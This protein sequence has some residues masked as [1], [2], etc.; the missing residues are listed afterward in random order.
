MDLVDKYLLQG[1]DRAAHDFNKDAVVAGGV[2]GLGDLFQA[3]KLRQRRRVVLGALQND[4]DKAADV[5]A[6]LF[7]ANVNARAGDN[8]RLF[9]LLYPDVDGPRANAKLLRQFGIGRAGIGH[10][11]LQNAPVE[12]VDLVI[13]HKC[14]PLL[15]SIELRLTLP[16]TQQA[17][18]HDG[19][20]APDMIE[21]TH[22]PRL[23]VSRHCHR[24][25]AVLMHLL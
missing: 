15:F 23:A 14:Q 22:D 17:A 5:I 25:K 18:A 7:R 3:F 16:A 8:A 13:F 12:V 10:Q 20:K 21:N 19:V 2:V 11:R 4:A 1:V 24:V 9:H 6:E